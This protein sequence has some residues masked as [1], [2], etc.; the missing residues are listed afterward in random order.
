HAAVTTLL[1]EF[2]EWTIKTVPRAENSHAD[3]L[4]NEALDRAR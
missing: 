2:D 3:R 4:V 1:R